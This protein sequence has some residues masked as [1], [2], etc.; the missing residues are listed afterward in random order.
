M[1]KILIYFHNILILKGILI[2]R[3]LISLKKIKN[4]KCIQNIKIYVHNF[5]RYSYF[6]IY[7]NIDQLIVQTSN[8][9]E[10]LYI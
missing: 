8:P 9:L 7:L 10:N 2:S 5:S 1:K 3:F 4:L 6:R